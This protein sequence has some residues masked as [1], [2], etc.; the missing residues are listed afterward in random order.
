MLPLCFVP[1]LSLGKLQSSLSYRLT[2]ASADAHGTQGERVAG[3]HPKKSAIMVAVGMFT[4]SK[5]CFQLP[6]LFSGYSTGI[7]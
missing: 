1:L 5:V 6:G 4:A 2:L 7:Q 3:G